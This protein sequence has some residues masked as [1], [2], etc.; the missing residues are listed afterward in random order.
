MTF[1]PRT[2]SSFSL[3]A[4]LARNFRALFRAEVSGSW[5]DGHLSCD[6]NYTLRVLASV[7]P[8][9]LLIHIMPRG[10]SG[11]SFHTRLSDEGAEWTARSLKGAYPPLSS[12]NQ[13]VED[14]RS[15]RVFFYG[16]I[17]PGDEDNNPTADFHVCDTQTMTVRNITVSICFFS[18]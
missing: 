12:Q 3:A 2:S 5:S 11:H 17:A 14:E 8:G 10:S 16:G 9:L 15:K 7:T 13:I 6:L 4:H 18:N 1:S